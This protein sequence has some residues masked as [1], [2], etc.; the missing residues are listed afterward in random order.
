M[1][2]NYIPEMERAGTRGNLRYVAAAAAA[3]AAATAVFVASAYVSWLGAFFAA[4]GGPGLWV[5]YALCFAAPAALWAAA[6]A[7]LA[8]RVALRVA[9]VFAQKWFVYLVV[10]LS[11]AGV[12]YTARAVLGDAPLDAAASTSL[13]QSKIF[14]RGK[15]AAPAP[16]TEGDLS[17]AYFRSRGEVVRFG[18]WFSA[19]PPLHP[20]LLWL[21]RA[22]GW[23]KLVPVIAAAITLV[24]VYSL[25]RKALGP[26][27]GAVAALLA[28]TSPLF[29]FTQ[30]SYSS[31]ATFVCFFALAA[32]A[33]WE[34]GNAPSKKAA[35]ALGAA[36][37][38]AFLISSYTAL[39]LTPAFGWYMW[40]QARRAGGRLDWP[41]W[42][43]AGLAPFI[44]AWMLYNLGQT[45]NVFLPP[46]FFASA[47]FLGFDAAYGLRD[48]LSA[49]GR[50]FLGLS[51]SAFGW[52]L[53]CLVP[54]IWRLCWKPRPNDFERTLYAAALLA[55]AAQ[56][57][58]RDGGAGF[59]AGRYYPAW[60]CLAFITAKF[61]VI[62]AAK[63][64]RRFNEAGEGLA[65]FVIIGLLCVS[66]VAYWPLALRHYAFEARR[67][68]V[69]PWA[70]VVTRRVA[71]AIPGRAVVII[72]PRAACRGPAPGSPFLDDRVVF[73]RDNGE[74]NSELAEIFPGREFYLLD[75][76]A[77]KRTGEI[78][79]LELK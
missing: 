24:A 61:F 67:I 39:Y 50:G 56:L 66:A 60:F 45:G 70:E 57:P 13:F 12:A 71:E 16:P 59:A 64:Q 20:A 3:T 78:T 33:C 22:A 14:C 44:A 4:L 62:L 37:G 75:Y 41:R 2:F 5:K 40:R 79:P 73:A 34:V 25:G 18:R 47:P 10:A 31:Q 77:F 1:S 17:R 65:A 27:G 49:T 21:G 68:A 38:A 36:A 30:A 7:K 74:N 23:P 29:I 58:A 51:T 26:F 53:L 52:P 63:A 55:F 42:F 76:P 9:G 54:A 48:A 28:A 6:A 72:K 35:L 32:R 15:L 43:A 8:P 11:T 46:H 69:S 19:S